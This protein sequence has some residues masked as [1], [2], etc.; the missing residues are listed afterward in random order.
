MHIIF[1]G[2]RGIGKAIAKKFIFHNRN[3]LVISRTKPSALNCEHFKYDFS[4]RNQELPKIKEIESI[5]FCQKNR[6]SM[7]NDEEINFS[8]LS[9]LNILRELKEN[10]LK[11]SLILLMGSGASEFI[12]DEQPASYHISKGSIIQLTK[13]LSIKLG[14]LG[15][16]ANCIIPGTVLKD[17]N[18]DFYINNKELQEM[19]KKLIPRGEIVSSEEIAEVAFFLTS[20]LSSCIT[21]QSIYVEAGVSNIGQETIARRILGLEHP[22]S[23]L[24][25]NII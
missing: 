22:S 4:A 8:V 7:E 16:R 12:V 15:V 3:V 17:E 19:Y 20:N 2:S 13:Y 9:I 18:K 1:G 23:N 14:N 25:D 21:V 10:F 5:V 6:D 24:Y 11:N